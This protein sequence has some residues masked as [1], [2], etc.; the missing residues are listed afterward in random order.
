MTNMKPHRKTI[1][2]KKSK[3]RNRDTS[4]Q[5]SGDT[6]QIAYHINVLPKKTRLRLHT[7][8]SVDAI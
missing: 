2:S 4:G 7:S 3:S 1:E 8:F 6:I 5:T